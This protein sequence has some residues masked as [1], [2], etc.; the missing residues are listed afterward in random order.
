MRYIL[1]IVVAVTLFTACNK[2]TET[3]SPMRQTDQLL[4]WGASKDE[5]LAKLTAIKAKVVS[6]TGDAIVAEFGPEGLTSSDGR[7]F[8]KPVRVEYSFKDGKLAQSKGF[9]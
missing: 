2:K 1:I 8:T 4:A 9:P 5:V 7:Q 3:A 6:Q